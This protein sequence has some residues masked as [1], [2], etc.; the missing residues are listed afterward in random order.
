MYAIRS[1]YDLLAKQLAF[2]DLVIEGSK[3]S[4]TYY[5]NKIEISRNNTQSQM[6]ILRLGY[7]GPVKDLD[8]LES[9]INE[10]FGLQLESV[11]LLRNN[12]V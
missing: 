6:D 1:Y 5:L 8:D 4:L 10:L 9:A 11:E 3:S 7:L 2:K 12:F